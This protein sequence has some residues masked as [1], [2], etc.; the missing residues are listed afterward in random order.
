[1]TARVAGGRGFWAGPVRVNFFSQEKQTS[2]REGGGAAPRLY[3]AACSATFLSEEKQ[4][5]LRVDTEGGGAAPLYG[6]SGSATFLP[7][8]KQ[9]SLRVGAKGG[10]ASAQ[11]LVEFALVVPMFLLLIFAL[12]DFSRLL[13]TYISISNGAREMARTAAVSTNWSNSAA[14]NAFVNSTIVAAS[15]NPATDTV[16]VRA[17]SGAC[18]RRL[19][20]GL[21]CSPSPTSVTCTMPLSTAGCTL[22]S[23]TRGGFVEVQVDYTFQFNPLFQNRLSGVVDVSFMRPSARV[24]TTA[25]VYVE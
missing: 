7:E 13:F 9:T 8:E 10:G 11:S 25:R 17:G 22:P 23:P 1:V 14:L 3:G 15:Q 19:D 18:A 2:L 5:S 4:T 16:T 21:T 20:T 24:T 12:L 6:A